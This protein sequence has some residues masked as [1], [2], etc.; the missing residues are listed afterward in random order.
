ML[1]SR[2]RPEYREESPHSKV[3]TNKKK[4]THIWHHPAF[5]IQATS[6]GGKAQLHYSCLP[7][8]LMATYFN[9]CSYPNRKQ[10]HKKETILNGMWKILQQKCLTKFKLLKFYEIWNF[11]GLLEWYHSYSLPKEQSWK[12]VFCTVVP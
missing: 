4:S 9:M 8:L 3:R 2:G 6:A 11:G 5:C 12:V 10:Y 7:K 1:V